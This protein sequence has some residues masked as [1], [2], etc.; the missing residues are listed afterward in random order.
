[1]F[2]ALAGIIGENEEITV[3]ITAPGKDGRMKVVV[4]PKT[5][6][7]SNI[8]LAQPLA[9]AATP[10]DLDSGFVGALMEF[11]A[12]RTGLKEQVAV[13]ATIMAAAQ[14]SE[15]GKAT[16]ALQKSSQPAATA[17]PAGDDQRDDV[18]DEGD[19]VLDGPSAT[20]NTAPATPAA[21][22][23]AKSQAGANDDLLSLMGA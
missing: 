23:A 18:H 7:G 1:M 20:G 5:E 16:K 10:Q 12:S 3:K 15:A 14:K 22:P 13:T 4:M 11:G 8:A 9:L 2:T 19:D 17:D 21:P 6:K